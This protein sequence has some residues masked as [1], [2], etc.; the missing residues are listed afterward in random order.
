ME[1]G[2]KLKVRKFFWL[3]LTFVEVTG[4]KNVRELFCPAL[5]FPSILNTVNS[6]LALLPALQTL[7]H[8]LGDYSREL[9]SAHSYQPVLNWEILGGT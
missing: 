5:P 8:K 2:L 7:N 1:K 6:T 9:A 3:I 4:E